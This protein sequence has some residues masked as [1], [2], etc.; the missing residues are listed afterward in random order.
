M[1]ALIIAAHPDLESSRINRTLLDRVQN[2]P[3]I[4][5]HSLYS[6]YPDWKIDVKREQGLLLAHDRIVFQFPLYWY[7][8]PPLLKKWQD[9]VLEYGWA[10]AE[11]GDNLKGKQFM[12][13][14][15]IGVHPD[16]YRAGAI[17]E[18]TLSEILRPLQ[19]TAVFCQ[20]TYLP[21]FITGGELDD[22]QLATRADEYLATLQTE[23][24]RGTTLP[25]L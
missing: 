12:L 13:A 3:D 20:M 2:Q 15:S 16:C 23:R 10:F 25:K 17:G 24:P 8:T 22:A 21:A 14:T 4:T 6:A 9:D 1:K 11:G 19:A 5:V 7:S 18:F